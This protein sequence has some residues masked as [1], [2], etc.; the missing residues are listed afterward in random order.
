MHTTLDK[1]LTKFEACADNEKYEFIAG[2][3]SF[4]A[5][6]EDLRAYESHPLYAALIEFHLF[7]L[8]AERREVKQLLD[9]RKADLDNG[10]HFLPNDT[11]SGYYWL[12]Q[13]LQTRVNDL[14]V[15]IADYRQNLA[16][17]KD[18]SQ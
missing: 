8:E 16:K 7:H 15:L 11:L 13:Q 3:K 10:K 5:A 14:D 9:F 12:N 6:N 1:I 18:I 17:R 2:F 4:L